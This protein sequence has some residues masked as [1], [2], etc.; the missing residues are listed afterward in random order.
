MHVYFKLS[1]NS[2]TKMEWSQIYQKRHVLN[3]PPPRGFIQRMNGWWSRG[4]WKLESSETTPE[5]VFRIIS[6]FDSLESISREIEINSI[7]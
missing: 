2:P 6:R 4:G 1:I 7:N 5:R 3:S